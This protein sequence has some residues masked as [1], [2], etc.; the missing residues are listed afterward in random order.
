[1]RCGPPP[2]GTLNRQGYTRQAVSFSPALPKSCGTSLAGCPTWSAGPDD[3]PSCGRELAT[4]LG[5]PDMKECG[6]LHCSQIQLGLSMPPALPLHCLPRASPCRC[7]PTAPVMS[8]FL[9]VPGV[10]CLRSNSKC[11]CHIK[12]SDNR[13]L[14]PRIPAFY[15]FKEDAQFMCSPKPA[16]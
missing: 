5:I 10:H 12:K 16:K 14:P 9:S 11:A 3:C 2:A 4:W 13:L 15:A 8:L 6:G 7:N 1:M